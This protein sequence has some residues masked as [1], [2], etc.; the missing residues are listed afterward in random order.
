MYEEVIRQ[1]E[2]LTVKASED[3][4]QVG[5]Y[6]VRLSH[7]R[8]IDDEHS[9][10]VLISHGYGI[11]WATQQNIISPLDGLMALAILAIDEGVTDATPAVMGRAL[12]DG[13]I[14]RW[15]EVHCPDTPMPDFD[16]DGLR[17][18]DVDWVRKG[19][20]FYLTPN[21]GYESIKFVRDSHRLYE[22]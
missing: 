1:I 20:V 19:S 21:D 3:F 4:I 10:A 16:A 18:C 11:G 12:Y 5:D 7:G 22:A 9:R 13:L 6:N 14:Q 15:W 8:L 2:E 17:Q